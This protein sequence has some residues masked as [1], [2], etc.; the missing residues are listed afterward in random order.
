MRI[1]LTNDDGVQSAGLKAL[2]EALLDI[3]ELVIVAPERQQSAAGHAITLHK[4]LRMNPAQ[5][6]GLDIQPYDT[7]GTPADCVILGI[8]AT[9]TPPDLVIS[10][11][12]AGANL[13]EE[14]LYSG[15]VSAAMEAVLQELPAFAIS[16]TEY[17]C[18]KFEA[19]AQ[20]ARQLVEDWQYVDLCD[21]G[22]L[23]INVPSL[24]PD[25]IKGIEVTRLGKRA[26]V[27]EVTRR[28]DPRGQP[29]YWFSG[30]AQEL[31]GGEGTDIGVVAAGRISI[32]PVHFNLTNYDGISRL[33]PLVER[34]S[35]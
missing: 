29:Y 15:T 5:I 11:I 1:L 7:N 8:L 17:D 23:N 9:G 24:P 6:E 2:A 22:F 33:E 35:G 30:E 34:L 10:G 27:N 14:I 25:E 26:Y 18:P 12:N 21:G 32:T 31:D 28:E 16:V 19:A 13:G 20:F 3:A 4:P